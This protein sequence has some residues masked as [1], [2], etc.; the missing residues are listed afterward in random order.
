[1]G[2]ATSRGG[3]MHRHAEDVSFSAVTAVPVLGVNQG[4]GLNQKP[5]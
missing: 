5:D 3:G 4:T 1:M 2:R